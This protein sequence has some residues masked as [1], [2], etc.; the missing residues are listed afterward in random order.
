MLTGG[1]LADKYLELAL[2]GHVLQLLCPVSE[3]RL[4]DFKGNCLFFTCIKLDLFKALKLL[5]GTYARA[6]YVSYV[7]LN[8]FLSLVLAWVLN[9][10]PPIVPRIDPANEENIVWVT[11]CCI[12]AMLCADIVLAYMCADAFASIVP[13]MVNSDALNNIVCFMMILSLVFLMLSSIIA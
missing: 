1:I 4:G 11:E 10:W 8:R 7:E 9:F 3:H 12:A 13:N 6:L 5:N 2:F